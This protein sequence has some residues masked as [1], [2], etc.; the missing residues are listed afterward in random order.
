MGGP[1]PARLVE[2]GHDVRALGRSIKKRSELDQLGAH[3]VNDT[4]DA[5]AQAGGLGALDET[6]VAKGV[7]DGSV[8][9]FPVRHES[10]TVTVTVKDSAVSPPVPL[11]RIQ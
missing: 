11:R 1:M 10:I 2:A 9:G 8:L 6:D 7:R 3:A 4:A 5:G